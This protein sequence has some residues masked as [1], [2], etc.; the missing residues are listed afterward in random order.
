MTLSTKI[1]Q[2]SHFY[3]NS[4]LLRSFIGAMDRSHCDAVCANCNVG[5]WFVLRQIKRNI[6]QRLFADLVATLA[7]DYTKRKYR[8]EE[9]QNLVELHILIIFFYFQVTS[10]SSGAGRAATCTLATR[11]PWRRG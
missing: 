2:N 9:L 7:A 3:T 5:D 6:D 1:F 8:L 10:C 11:T 4:W